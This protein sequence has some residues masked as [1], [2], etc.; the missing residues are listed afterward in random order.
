LDKW[1][2]IILSCINLETMSSEDLTSEVEQVLALRE[3]KIKMN[4]PKAKAT[5]LFQNL[6]KVLEAHS[7]QTLEA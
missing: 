2:L 6:V 3:G 1:I 7:D 4:L 5:F